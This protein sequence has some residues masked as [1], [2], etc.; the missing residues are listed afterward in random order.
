MNKIQLSTIL[1]LLIT[2]VGC[3]YDNKEELYPNNGSNNCDTT[4]LTYNQS[5]KTLINT[6][7]AYSGCHVAGG[8]SPNLSTYTLLKASISSVKTR[9]IDVKNMP[10]PSGMSA[11]NINK[12]SIWITKGMPE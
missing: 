3:Y 7:C 5:I 8:T 11:C 10:S 6:N 9:A 2:T 4:N 12:L 1:L